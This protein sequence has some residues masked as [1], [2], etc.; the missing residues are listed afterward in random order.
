S[1]LSNAG[2]NLIITT[3]IKSVQYG[4]LLL[5]LG[6]ALT[7]LSGSGELVLKS[8]TYRH[9]LA[10]CQWEAM[11]ILDDSE[12]PFTSFNHKM[13]I[14]IM[15]YVLYAPDWLVNFFVTKVLKM[16]AKTVTPSMLQDIKSG[17]KTE[18]DELQGEIVRLG[19]IIRKD[20]DEGAIIMDGVKVGDCDRSLT[21]YNDRVLELVK[22]VE[23]WM[24]V[25]KEGWKV[26]IEADEVLAFI[27]HGIVP[28]A[29]QS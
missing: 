3:N 18:I 11:E 22:L 19:K 12:I 4:K 24:E 13:P 23:E 5:N 20:R 27:E 2:I 21:P 16:D 17:R 1:I 29:L 10:M 28:Q 25:H 26:S 8:E 9:I 14:R 6:N 15:P 7:A